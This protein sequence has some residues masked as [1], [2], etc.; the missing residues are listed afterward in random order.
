MGAESI[1]DGGSASPPDALPASSVQAQQGRAGMR[2]GLIVPKYMHSAVD[3]NRLKRRLK[4]LA[5]LRLLPSG[6]AADVVIRVRPE[7]YQA[8]F[9]ALTADIARALV[10]LARWQ[11]EQG[12]P[13][14]QRHPATTDARPRPAS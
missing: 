3:R 13:E 14:G 1:M 5:R 8:S 2:V 6:V 4:E 9:D 12:R 11:E 7:A 10:Q